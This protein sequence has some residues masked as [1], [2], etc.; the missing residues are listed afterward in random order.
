MC[1]FPTVIINFLY[2]NITHLNS[3]IQTVYFVRMHLSSECCSTVVYQHCWTILSVPTYM[4]TGGTWWHSWLRHCT[5]SW[6]VAGSIPN[7]VIRIFHWHNPDCTMAL[8]SIQP[9]IEMSTRNINWGL[10]QLMCRADSLTTFMCWL[11]WNV[12]ATPSWNLHGL[13]RNCCTFHMHACIHTFIPTYVSTYT[14][15]YI[16]TVKTVL[17]IT[18]L[19][20]NLG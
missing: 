18:G 2:Q 13:S 3:A 14:P 4:Y 1:C 15:T 12:W 5:S 10:R 19:S 20:G 7:G 8:W 9:L 17:S 11:P 6:K 16:Y